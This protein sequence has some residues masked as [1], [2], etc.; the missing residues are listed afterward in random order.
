MM[1]PLGGKLMLSFKKKGIQSNWC[2]GATIKE[3]LVALRSLSCGEIDKFYNQE[4]AEKKL[5]SWKSL[6]AFRAREDQ[7][8]KKLQVLGCSLEEF[9]LILGMPSE[10]LFGDHFSPVWLKTI[11]ESEKSADIPLPSIPVLKVALQRGLVAPYL[12]L[13]QFHC[14]KFL[15]E[16]ECNSFQS[17]PFR[18]PELLL[19]MF[20]TPFLQVFE[21]NVRRAVVLEINVQRLL[22]NLKGESSNDRYADFVR[23]C[24]E[25]SSFRLEFLKKYTVLTRYAEKSLSY[26]LRSSL[27]FLN[28]FNK[29]FLEISK[30]FAIDAGDQISALQ[31]GGDTHHHGRA[32]TMVSFASGRKITYKPRN[33]QIDLV[34]QEYL[35]WFNREKVDVNFLQLNI[36]NKNDYGWIQFVDYQKT[37]DEKEYLDFYRNLGALL[38]VLYSINTVDIHFE[39]LVASG[40]NPIVIDLETLFHVDLDTYSFKSATELTQHH[41]RN[42]VMGIGILPRPSLSSTKGEIFDVSG[43]GASEHQK[44]P[45][46]VVGIQN[47]GRDDV[48]ITHVP[49]WIPSVHNRP[50]V[51]AERPI[52]VKSILDGFNTVY[53]FLLLKKAYLLSDQSPLISFKSCSRRLIARDT[54]RY[55]SLQMDAFHPDLLKDHIDTD[56]HWDNLWND[57][58]HRPV[59][60]NFQSSEFAQLEDFDIPHFHTEVNGMTVYDPDGKQIARLSGASGWQLVTKLIENLSV[61]DRER[62]N[63]FIRTSLGYLPGNQMLVLNGT[64][65]RN[66]LSLARQVGD[67]LLD[68][69]FSWNNQSCFLKPTSLFSEHKSERHAVAITDADESLYEGTAGV[70]LFLAYLGKSTDDQ[71]YEEAA[72]SLMNNIVFNLYEG[73]CSRQISGY[74][75]YGSIA[76]V[77]NHFQS[78]YGLSY[79]HDVLI[80]LLSDIEYFVKND[81]SYDV[82]SG[83][84]G[85]ILGMLTLMDRPGEVGERAT[86]IARL[87]ADHLLGVAPSKTEPR[88]QNVTYKRGFSHGFGGIGASLCLL[89]QKLNDFEILSAA[90]SIL[91]AEHELIQDDKW[92][93]D[94][95]IGKR[96]QV[97]WCHGAPGIALSRII[98]YPILKKSFL[99]DDLHAAIKETESHYWM[100]SHCLC[101]GTLGNL[102]TLILGQDRLSEFASLSESITAKT[103]EVL[104]ALAEGEWKSLLISQT[105]SLGLLTGISGVGFELLRMHDKAN[106]PSVLILEGPKS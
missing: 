22:G 49:G 25:N 66:H 45:Y 72:K 95:K 80:D 68:K 21:Y 30:T 69:L 5:S 76:Y 29:D 23:L 8:R 62:Q 11:L 101:H 105:F 51:G 100:Q 31:I 13:I 92:T 83:S 94:H 91:F 88:W 34:F 86:K 102:E 1:Q 24:T 93:D 103:N 53:D 20:L 44:A 47:F 15:A 48:A 55:G 64:S 79:L 9:K 10:K 54:K 98:S 42:S 7:F 39:N 56:W 6:S 85:C 28:R 87:C 90:E 19:D 27:E 60:E 67:Q 33:L 74:I 32:V 50:D 26:W 38:A 35:D 41:V 14:R 81:E 99:S 40:P 36:I 70:A 89:G 58:I 18:S 106:V 46:K 84:A 82:L 75:G 2:N 97:S 59:V 65:N 17:S 73:R 71:R 37:T 43:M 52:P 4:L 16:I 61:E 63:W 57:C 78:L 96:S 104:T 77:L 12:P 3:R